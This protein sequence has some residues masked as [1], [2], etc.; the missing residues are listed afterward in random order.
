MAFDAQR[1][2]TRFDLRYEDITQHGALRIDA[3]P[4]SLGALW[5]A[6]GIDEAVTRALWAHG[7]LPILARTE[8]ETEGGPFSV[9][10]PME[11][12]GGYTLSHGVDDDG[13][14]SRLFFDMDA[15]V[16][17][18]KGRTNLPPPSD[19]GVRCLAGRIRA[20]HVFT[21]PLAGPGD[22]KVLSL[23]IEDGSFVPETRRGHREP[24]ETL[25]LGPGDAAL[26]AEL[27]E[28]A[29]AVH[30]GASHTDSNQHVNSL[31]YP[32]LFEDAA[33]RRLAAHG[34]ATKLRANRVT[35]AYRKPSFAGDAV[36]LLLQAFVASDGTP[37]CVGVFLGEGDVDAARGR[38]YVHMRFAEVPARSGTT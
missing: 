13:Q 15:E 25:L 22:R 21:R 5:R 8:I 4:V 20:E 2:E 1:A 11:V 16:W 32:R 34:R 33:L 37:G 27:R 35:L 10:G 9:E 23:P 36:R 17:G 28:D 29:A 26:D 14:V 12:Q 31:V 19:A 7:I 18:T 6:L 3:L 30:F 24:T 38:V